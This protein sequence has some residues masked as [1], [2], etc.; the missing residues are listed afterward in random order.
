MTDIAGKAMK[1]LVLDE[2]R[3]RLRPYELQFIMVRADGGEVLAVV[4]R[5]PMAGTLD[6]LG[7]PVTI[8][9]SP[10]SNN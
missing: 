2:I 4:R 1:K 5:L 6:G 8:T 7:V 3:T 9:V 10:A